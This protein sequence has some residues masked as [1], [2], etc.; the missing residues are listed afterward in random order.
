[1]FSYLLQFWLLFDCRPSS[2]WDLGGD[3]IHEDEIFESEMATTL[4]SPKE[5]FKKHEVD[6]SRWKSTDRLK[7]LCKSIDLNQTTDDEMT[8]SNSLP[9]IPQRK[10]ARVHHRTKPWLNVCKTIL[11]TK[12]CISTKE[13]ADICEKKKA[14]FTARQDHEFQGFETI[15]EL[16]DCMGVATNKV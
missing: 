11:S 9:R 16:L 10:E 8:K 14:H 15:E 12:G 4:P 13:L 3:T 6:L 2:K 7:S 1:M 5:L